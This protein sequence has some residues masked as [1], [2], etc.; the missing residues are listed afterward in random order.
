MPEHLRALMVIL[1]LAAAVFVAARA[2]AC[3]AATTGADFARRRTLWFAVTLA[4]FLSHDYW[5]FIGAA[6]ALTAAKIAYGR[7]TT[8]RAR[9]YAGKIV[10]VISATP[11]SLITA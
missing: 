10:V 2:P 5:L 7:E 3:A 6:T 11:S 1:A 9:K 4:A 8:R